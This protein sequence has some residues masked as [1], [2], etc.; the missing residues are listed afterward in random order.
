MPVR[1]ARQRAQL[2]RG[3]RHS[4]F[5]RGRSIG[6]PSACPV[7][8]CGAGSLLLGAVVVS[9]STEGSV[10]RAGAATRR[11]NGRRPTRQA[12]TSR[13][14]RGVVLPLHAPLLLGKRSRDVCGQRR[15]CPVRAGRCPGDVGVDHEFACDHEVVCH[16]QVVRDGVRFVGLGGKGGSHG[17]AGGQARRPRRPLA[18][19]RKRWDRDGLCHSVCT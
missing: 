14:Q 16:S 12:P 15:G 19:A 11:R 4:P 9:R 18:P 10:T 6:Q 13:P 17:H 3:S 2:G 8:L 1:G 7:V 5:P